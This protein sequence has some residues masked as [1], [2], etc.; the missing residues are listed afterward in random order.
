[1]FARTT[2]S[3]RL[4]RPNEFNADE[5]GTLGAQLLSK[6][7]DQ[8]STLGDRLLAVTKMDGVERQ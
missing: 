6:H 4:T 2:C 5:K 3:Q 8:K 7:A 1:M